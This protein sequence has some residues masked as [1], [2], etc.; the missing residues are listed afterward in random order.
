MLKKILK[1]IDNTFIF[2]AIIV[3]SLLITI[4][5]VYELPALV[6]A[7]SA[8]REEKAQLENDIKAATEEVEQL[9]DPEKQAQIAREQYNLSEKDEII[10]VFPDE[11]E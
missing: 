2:L 5:S 3:I 7:T 6:D 9:Q 1:L 10:F 11:A 4:S 8:M